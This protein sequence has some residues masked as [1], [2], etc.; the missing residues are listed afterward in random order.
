MGLA[1]H[2]A[3]NGAAV[4]SGS[5]HTAHR[6]RDVVMAGAIVRQNRA[7]LTCFVR[8]REIFVIF[9]GSLAMQT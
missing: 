9:I 5:A 2:R 8:E 6:G 7:R 1:A 4:W 3:H